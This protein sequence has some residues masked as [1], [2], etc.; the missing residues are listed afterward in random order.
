VPTITRI[1][2]RKKRNKL[3]LA[4]LTPIFTIV[5]IVGWALY[6]IGQSRNIQPQP[7][8]PINK[9]PSQ[10]EEIELIVIP[11]EFQQIQNKMEP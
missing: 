11:Q 10:Q 6:W 7:Q 1:T 5:F 8:K 3:T 9:T 4:L 2:T